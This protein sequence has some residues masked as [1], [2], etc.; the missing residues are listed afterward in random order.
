VATAAVLARW[1]TRRLPYAA[2]V[3]ISVLVTASLL[4]P[5]ALATWKHADERVEAGELNAVQQ[6]CAAFK[7]GDV[8]L[9]VDSRAANEWPQV[10]RGFCGVPALSTTTALRA[11]PAR[12]GSAVEQVKSAVDGRGGRL[13]LVAADSGQSLRRLGLDSAVLA[14]NVRVHED[15]RLL[16]RRPDHLVT[17][18]IQVWLGTPR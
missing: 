9:M 3:V 11:D 16:E 5:T 15:P 7:P 12:L 17:L 6:V 10:L 1:S 2:L 8:A 13:V 18:P 4:V 14:V